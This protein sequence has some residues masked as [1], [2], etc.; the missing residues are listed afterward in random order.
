M[1]RERISEEKAGKIAAALEEH[2]RFLAYVRVNALLHD[3]DKSFAQFLLW[4]LKHS[5]A[6]G[7]DEHHKS[8]E[9]GEVSLKREEYL[10]YWRNAVARTAEDLNDSEYISF[11]A[12]S[13][14]ATYLDEKGKEKYQITQEQTVPCHS[15]YDFFTYHHDWPNC[16]EQ[17]KASTA[18]FLFISGVAGI[19]GN[20][21]GYESEMEAGSKN[22]YSGHHSPDTAQDNIVLIST[23][24]GFERPVDL[25][26]AEA[27]CHLTEEI[28][29][30]V[31]ALRQDKQP[32]QAAARLEK[33]LEQPF[34]NTVIRT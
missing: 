25:G 12:P 4:S 23:P 14:Y 21:T 24:F 30:V 27:A 3:C 31:T 32:M 22:G 8:T 28:Q 29:N 5:E 20:D 1:D 17:A 13:C 2:C 18:L 33:K 16:I 15:I 19:D 7:Y 11:P 9:P 10:H 6:P 26:C 34:L